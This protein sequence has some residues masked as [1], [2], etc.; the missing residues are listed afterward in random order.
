M[1]PFHA[2]K[3]IVEDSTKEREASMTEEEFSVAIDL[4]VSG[5]KEGLSLIY[6]KYL[7]FIYAI[8]YNVLESK[9]EAEDVTSEFFIKL[10]RI[11]PK[12][13]YGVGHKAWI[14]TVAKNMALDYLRKNS[15]K[16]NY[17]V[18]TMKEV[19]SKENL[20]DEVILSNDMKN[21]MKVL[22][23]AEKEVLDL[24]L[25]GGFTFKEISQTLKKPMGT[26]TWIYNQAITKLRRCLG[27]YE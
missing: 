3:Y 27:G 13:N 23:P 20:E 18:D 4:L 9:E 19:A 5:N 7:R 14:A 2:Y 21:A 10:I 11:A 16:A 8:I 22:K 17:D 1:K 24:K 12:Y 6:E 25:I 26:V 15:K